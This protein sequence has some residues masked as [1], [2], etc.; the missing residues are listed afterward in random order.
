MTPTMQSNS[1]RPEESANPVKVSQRRMVWTKT[2][3]MEAWTCVACA[4]AFRPSGPPVGNSL[5][6]MKLNYELKRDR[7]FASHVCAM[8]PK[9]GNARNACTFSQQ[10]DNR[11]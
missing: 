8:C 11:I 1:T 10:A 4:W 6:E 3:Q 2:P 7:E 5:E 9:S